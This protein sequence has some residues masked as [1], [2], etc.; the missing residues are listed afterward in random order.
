[1]RNSS[2][3]VI[4]LRKRRDLIVPKLLSGEPKLDDALDLV[5]IDDAMGDA[6]HLIEIIDLLN[7]GKPAPNEILRVLAT[8]RVLATLL[9]GRRY[10]L[11][12]QILGD[13]LINLDRDFSSYAAA[14]QKHAETSATP[15]MELRSTQGTLVRRACLWYEVNLGLGQ[16]AQAQ[17]VADLTLLHVTS[18]SAYVQL[19]TIANRL[20]QRELVQQLYKQGMDSLPKGPDRERLRKVVGKGILGEPQ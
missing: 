6:G 1:V 2:S 19:C 4:E 14:L 8:E 15:S 20:G 16:L 9:S 5:A 3:V 18:A 7:M 12:S 17:Q 13:E 11:L 10:E